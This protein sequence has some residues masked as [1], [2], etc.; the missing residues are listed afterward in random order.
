MIVPGTGLLRWVA[1]VV[2]PAAALAALVPAVG[3]W[4]LVLVGG[5][6]LAA[7]WDAW[8]GH[9]IGRLVAVRLPEAV[10]LSVGRPGR[11][12]LVVASADGR[13]HEVRVGVAWPASVGGDPEILTV[14]V[15]AGADRVRV[16]WPC[17]GWRRGR[18]EVSGCHV[19]TASPWG[20]WSMRRFVPQA[21]EFRLYPNLM[22]ERRQVS[23]VFMRRGLVGMHQQ[24]LVGK[25]REFEKLRDYT[26]G[27]SYEDIHWKATAKRGRP[28]TKLFQVER[29]QEV[30]V[31]LDT[32]RLLG[33]TPDVEGEEVVPGAEGRDGAAERTRGEGVPALERFVSAAL[34]L[35]LAAER[36]GDRFGLMVFADRVQGFLRASSGRAHFNACRDLLLRAACADVAP[37]FDEAFSFVRV[38]LRHRALLLVLTALD[39][40]VMAETFERGVGLVARQHLVYANVLRW[41][42]LRPLFSGRDPR[43]AQEVYGRL[44]GHLRWRALRE[45]QGRLQHRGVRL[46]WIEPEGLSAGL[47]DQYLGVKQ[48]QQL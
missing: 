4:C 35:A 3:G 45:L 12:E 25:G 11:M 48:R 44:S 6:V 9:E 24:R 34:I 1:W 7:L 32:S 37:D 10:R 46:G 42:E 17:T 23:S 15:P 18:E 47:V 31:L 13:A 5:V 27:D 29:T 33:R 21:V 36:A 2:V 40:P 28:L 8:R 22:A 41:G 38:R 43:T 39:D 20:W 14:R 26:V 16:A 19:E 30:Y